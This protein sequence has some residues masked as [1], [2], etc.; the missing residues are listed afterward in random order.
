MKT[1]IRLPLLGTCLLALIILQG[2]NYTRTWEQYH[3]LGRQ[4]FQ[5]GN[6]VEAEGHWLDAVR[7]AEHFSAR[8]PRLT[9]TLVD[10]AELYRI[11]QRD[12]EAFEMSRRALAPWGSAA[13]VSD[14]QVAGALDRARAIMTRYAARNSSQ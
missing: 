5:N 9:A 12:D 13:S 3:L 7:I 8:D 11:E 14:S 4:S 6:Y 2:C 1:P 10:L